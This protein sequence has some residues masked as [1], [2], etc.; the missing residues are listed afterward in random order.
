MYAQD[1]SG[2]YHRWFLPIEQALLCETLGE[3]RQTTALLK[4]WTVYS[5]VGLSVIPEGTEVGFF[6]GV[7][8]PKSFPEINPNV[9]W[10][11]EVF[12]GCI[13]DKVLQIPHISEDGAMWDT[14]TSLD[15]YAQRYSEHTNKPDHLDTGRRVFEAVPGGAVQ[16]LLAYA[17][18]PQNS[19]DED[20]RDHFVRVYELPS[21]TVSHEGKQKPIP[22]YPPKA[23]KPGKNDKIKH[24]WKWQRRSAWHLTPDSHLLDP[25][26]DQYNIGLLDA[27]RKAEMIGDE[28][29]KGIRDTIRL[30]KGTNKE[31]EE[32]A[33]LCSR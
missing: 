10:Q 15:Q 5:R 19:D 13:S 22:D 28:D 31:F 21:L 7:I 3:Y 20:N 27:L 18:P 30:V 32:G 8:A 9:L 24:Q 25:E 2:G 11:D 6:M 17:D 29:Y 14:L 4:E 12:Q 26:Y 1:K 16:F 23:R 33:E